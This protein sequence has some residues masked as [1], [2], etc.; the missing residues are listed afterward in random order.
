MN[1]P[2]RLADVSTSLR[3]DNERDAHL[4]GPDGACVTCKVRG[5]HMP[6]AKIPPTITRAPKIG[7]FF[8]C[9]FPPGAISPEMW[10]TR[11]V[12]V[13]SH[14]SKIN[15]ICTVVPTSSDEQ[16]CN[17]WSFALARSIDGKPSWALCNQITSISTARLQ[18]T[19]KGPV[20]AQDGDIQGILNKIREWMPAPRA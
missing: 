4:Y 15:G 12:I 7:Q 18:M 11:P 6:P 5:A 2:S 10:K 14:R 8:W 13:V 9:P 19:G 16:D 1:I 3:S 20:I 17:P